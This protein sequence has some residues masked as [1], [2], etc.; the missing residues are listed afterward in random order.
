MAKKS[1][2]GPD[3]FAD[4]IPGNARK[5]TKAGN[6][7]NASIAGNTSKATLYLPSDLLERL[8]NAACEERVP[9]GQIAEKALRSYLA[10]AEKKRGS[11]YPRRKKAALRPGRPI[12]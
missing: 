12:A 7:S 10:R 11:P 1:A 6:A 2:L 8:R 3:P 5:A 4:V 9:L